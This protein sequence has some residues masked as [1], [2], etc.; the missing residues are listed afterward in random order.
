[1]EMSV[2]TVCALFTP[3]SL[4]CW[5]LYVCAEVETVVDRNRS[6]IEKRSVEDD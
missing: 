3:S 6:E 4:L 1:M 5:A 2:A